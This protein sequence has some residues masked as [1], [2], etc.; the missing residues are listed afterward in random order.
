[1]YTYVLSQSISRNQYNHLWPQIQTMKIQSR[2]PPHLP[3]SP[4]HLLYLALPHHYLKIAKVVAVVAVVVLAV[5][6]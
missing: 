4:P 5:P 2:N 6:L 3:L 1:M